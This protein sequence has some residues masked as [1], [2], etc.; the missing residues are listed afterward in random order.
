MQYI[1]QEFSIANSLNNGIVDTYSERLSVSTDTKIHTKC[2]MFT[3][4]QNLNTPN[5]CKIHKHRDTALNIGFFFL[6]FPDFG[7]VSLKPVC[8][9]DGPDQKDQRRVIY[10]KPETRR[11]SASDAAVAKAYAISGPLEDNGFRS[12]HGRLETEFMSPTKKSPPSAFV[13]RSASSDHAPKPSVWQS[14]SAHHYRPEYATEP[15]AKGGVK[16]SS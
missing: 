14:P 4:F 3:H 8:F 12:R 2:S 5:V 9:V 15:R 13:H 1:F 6:F 16:S 7:Q 10:D 11:R